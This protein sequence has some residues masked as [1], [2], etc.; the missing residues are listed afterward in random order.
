[1]DN[2]NGYVDFETAKFLKEN[3]FNEEC[4]YCYAYFD[5]DD[6]RVLELNPSKKAQNLA[7][8]RYPYVTQQS[9]RA[10]LR[11]NNI[12]IDIDTIIATDKKVHYSASIWTIEDGWNTIAELAE[13]YEAAVDMALKYC[14]KHKRWII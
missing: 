6:V 4:E 2:N 12:F 5:D 13:S 11:K 10:W 1:M 7:E 8:N 14:Y 3:G 9:A